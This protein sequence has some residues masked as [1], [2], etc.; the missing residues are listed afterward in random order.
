MGAVF[1]KVGALEAR[2]PTAQ[3]ED[4]DEGEPSGKFRTLTDL[5]DGERAE[6][7]RFQRERD[8]EEELG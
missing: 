1:V 4:E 6:L 7:L 2:F 8:Q 5:D 3:R